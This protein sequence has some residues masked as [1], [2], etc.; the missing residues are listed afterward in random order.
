MVWSKAAAWYA[1]P[2][3]LRPGAAVLHYYEGLLAQ[4]VQARD[5][6]PEEIVVELSGGLDSANVAMTV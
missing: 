5:S 4:A 1:L 6:V 3:T 2:R